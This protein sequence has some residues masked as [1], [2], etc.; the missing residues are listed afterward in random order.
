MCVNYVEQALKQK[1][2]CLIISQSTRA[3]KS[4]SANCV[5]NILLTKQALRYIIGGIQVSA[6]T[7]SLIFRK[8]T[9]Y[10]KT[11]ISVA[12]ASRIG[13][14]G[15]VHTNSDQSRISCR[16]LKFFFFFFFII[17]CLQT[18]V[19]PLSRNGLKVVDAVDK[20]ILN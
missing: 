10:C 1:Q 11:L 3:R 17:N 2:T 20:C 18:D 8:Y 13:E 19:V 5:D 15:W 6:M 7:K 4:I 16:Y 12:S 9:Y 14:V